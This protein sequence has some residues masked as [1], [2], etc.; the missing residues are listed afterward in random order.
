M[1]MSP[2]DRATRFR[3]LGAAGPWAR[4]NREAEYDGELGAALAEDYN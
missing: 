3:R 1:S 4:R 2:R